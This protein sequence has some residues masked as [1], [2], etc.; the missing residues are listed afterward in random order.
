MECEKEGHMRAQCCEKMT[1]DVRTRQLV[2][3]QTE[4]MIM[5]ELEEEK[6]T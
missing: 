4:I 1:A 5:D 2:A 3:A 6:L